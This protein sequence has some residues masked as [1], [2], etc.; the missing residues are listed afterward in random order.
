MNEPTNVTDCEPPRITTARQSALVGQITR[1][2]AESVRAEI[3]IEQQRNQRDAEQCRSYSKTVEE[4][5]AKHE[6]DTE[7][8]HA[9]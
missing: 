7:A 2:A 5:T 6:A 9:L 1:L 8:D 4:L 3:E